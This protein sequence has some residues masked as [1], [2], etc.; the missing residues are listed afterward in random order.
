MEL[1]LTT[2]KGVDNTLENIR[3]IIERNYSNPRLKVF[4]SWPL[5]KIYNYV[6]DLPYIKDPENVPISG[7]DSLELLKR[8]DLTILTN[9]GDCDDKAILLAA[10]LK[11]KKVPFRMA[12]TSVTADKEFHHI[13]PEIFLEGRWLAFDATYPLW[14]KNY[15]PSQPF[16]E[17]QFT[18]KRIYDWSCGKMIAYNLDH[19][20]PETH[21]Q[22]S[23]YSCSQVYD[24][25]IPKIAGKVKPEYLGSDSR[26]NIKGTKLAVLEGNPGQPKTLGN[27]I[28]AAATIVA[29]VAQLF[30]GLFAPN[31]YQDAFNVWNAAAGALPGNVASQDWTMTGINRAIVAV[32]GVDYMNPPW[33]ANHC[34]SSG[35]CGNRA[36]WSKIQPDVE[37]KAAAA[38]P[39]YAWSSM[40]NN[41]SHS[42]EGLYQMYADFKSNGPLYQ[43]FLAETTGRSKSGSTGT[44][45]NF[46]GGSSTLLI[47]G[48]LGVGAWMVLK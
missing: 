15:T 2:Y 18:R 11:R 45:F 7:G 25:S 4:D 31:R 20:S 16:R 38:A 27:P 19:N 23:P 24:R 44:G 35:R 6:R 39:F 12:V 29:S 32:L 9:G 3:G 17:S 28:S 47:I 46:A 8:P 48:L 41:H 13:Y 42:M 30:S 5:Q 36:E 14:D 43:Q 26:G 10:I 37:S 40:K 34:T 1:T 21:L 33:G 22:K